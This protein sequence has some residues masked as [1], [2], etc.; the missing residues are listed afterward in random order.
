MSHNTT[1]QHRS[2]PRQKLLLAG[3]IIVLLVILIVIGAMSL[4]RGASDE[5]TS[6]T[7]V[8]PSTASSPPV[9]NSPDSDAVEGLVDPPIETSAPPAALPSASTSTSVCGLGSDALTGTVSEPPAAEWAFQ[10]TIAYPSSD[11]HGPGSV[12][13]DGIRTCFERSPEGAVFMA[14][15]AL[16][17]GADQ[18]T[19]ASWGEQSLAEGPYREEI[20]GDGTTGSSP[21]DTDARLSILGFRLSGYDGDSATVDIAVNGA[22]SGTVFM[23][24]MVYELVWQDGDWKVSADTPTPLT[25]A[26]IPDAVGYIPW[27]P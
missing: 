20:V 19:V 21:E 6:G 1:Q 10:G 4:A 13:P 5:E 8:P 27:T 15:N 23:M 24:S 18:T 25:A 7:H 9:E 16:S 26:Q 22:H 3:V 2:M 12:S 17:Q 14:V 11:A